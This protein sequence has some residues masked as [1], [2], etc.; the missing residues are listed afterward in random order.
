ME[1][2]KQGIKVEGSQGTA[3]V[4]SRQISRTHPQALQ[5]HMMSFVQRALPPVVRTC[6]LC[7][8]GGTASL[9]CNSS[10]LGAPQGLT[11]SA[12][13]TSVVFQAAAS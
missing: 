3:C 6:A 7:G 11:Q 13:L 1:L 2:A 5:G 12:I 10:V 8:S 9:R 4:A